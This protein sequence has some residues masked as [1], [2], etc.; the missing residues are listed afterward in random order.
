MQENEI[1]E[2]CGDGSSIEWDCPCCGRTIQEPR[3]LA[4][5]EAL[6]LLFGVG[7][8]GKVTE[9]RDV[10]SISTKIRRLHESV[11]YLFGQRRDR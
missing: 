1:C 5:P 9:Y 7:D 3:N 11:H 4:K 10:R 6:S 2:I 8:D